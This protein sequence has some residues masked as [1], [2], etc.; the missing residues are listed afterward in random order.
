MKSLVLGFALA[1]CTPY[2][3]AA[4]PPRYNSL[5]EFCLASKADTPANCECGQNTANRIM[6]S[7]EQAAALAMMQGDL[8]TVQKYANNYEQIMQK[9][10]IVTQGCAAPSP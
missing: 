2:L 3:L 4:E 1:L 8:A 6:S 5:K 9:I 10:S 7:E